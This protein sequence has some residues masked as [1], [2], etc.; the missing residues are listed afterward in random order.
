MGREKRNIRA[1]CVLC[2]M[3]FLLVCK[4][5]ALNYLFY[6][7]ARV[8]WWFWL[9]S[10][11][12]SRIICTIFHSSPLCDARTRSQCMYIK[13]SAARFSFSVFNVRSHGIC[14]FLVAKW[15]DDTL[16]CVI[17]I[18]CLYAISFKFV[19]WCISQSASHVSSSM[20]YTVYDVFAPDFT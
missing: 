12:N 1:Y 18:Q 3:Q 9:D 20:V 7:D 4:M 5:R 2:A 17:C 6:V 19:L 13:W 14:V 10:V 16:F 8:S 15:V 11:S